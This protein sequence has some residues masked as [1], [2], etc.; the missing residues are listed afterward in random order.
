MKNKMKQALDRELESVRVSSELKKRILTEAEVSR[1][2]QER[3]RTSFRPLAAAAAVALVVGLTAGIV[4]LRSEKPD[5]SATPLSAVK[6][7]SAQKQVWADASEGLYHVSADCSQ[8]EESVSMPLNDAR[9]LGLKGCSSCI[10]NGS[11]LARELVWM[12]SYGKYYHATKD[13]SGLTD[14]VGVLE[15]EA[16]TLDRLACPICI[17]EDD[18]QATPEPTAAATEAPFGTPTPSP[19]PM[20]TAAATE[21]PFGTPEPTAA[22]TETPFGTP[23]P[24]AV[25]TEAPFSMVEPTAVPTEAPADAFEPIPTVVATKAPAEAAS[26]AIVMN[27][28][29]NVSFWMTDGGVY[30]HVD[31]H[32]S[33]MEGAHECTQE[34]A[35]K[36]GKILCMVCM[37]VE[38][39]SADVVYDTASSEVVYDVEEAWVWTT[40]GGVYYHTDE[41]C[42]GMEGATG[43]SEREALAAGKQPCPICAPQISSVWATAEDKYYHLRQDCSGMVDA[44]EMTESDALAAGKTLCPNCWQ[45]TELATEEAWAGSDE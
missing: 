33:G 36:S 29:G 37:P 35:A 8:A 5:L 6:S 9:A 17:G 13:C 19:M 27:E 39:E 31:E 16:K 32:C 21:M 40:E 28:D 25:A 45:E 23:E 30:Y 43:C 15:V 26:A 14:A 38:T 1:M 22:A 34:E 44:Q 7:E 24:T 2:P 11:E 42:S 20:P 12:T 18:L 41:H 10:E 3:R 4:M